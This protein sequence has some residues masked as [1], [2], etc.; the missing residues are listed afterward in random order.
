MY[1]RVFFGPSWDFIHEVRFVAWASVAGASTRTACLDAWMSVKAV[2]EKDK[3]VLFWYWTGAGGRWKT[4]A[5]SPFADVT[6]SAIVV[7]NRA[8]PAKRYTRPGRLI[9]NFMANDR[10][11]TAEVDLKAQGAVCVT[12]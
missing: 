5:R 12:F 6:S 1:R 3:F 11:W 4:S 7:D 2:G 9:A 8:R 10:C